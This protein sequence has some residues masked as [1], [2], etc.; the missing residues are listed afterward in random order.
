V[1][2]SILHV[3]MDAFYASVELLRRPELRG[4][5]VVVGGAGARGVV[6][7]ASYEAR[8]YGVHS[9]MPALRARRL[10]P[11]AVFLAGDHPHYAQVSARLM[12]IFR[13]VTPLVEPLSLDEAF[14]DISGTRRL[15][16][17]PE[18]V[19]AWLR[20]RV[21]DEEQLSCSVGV[22]SNKFLAK[23]ATNRAKPRASRSGPIE[24]SGVFVVE[25]GSELDFLHPLP[26][27]DLWGVGP[28]T[29]AKLERLGIATVGDL[30]AAPLAALTASLGRGAATHLHELAHGR[31][32]RPVVPDQ[33]P[34]SV[35]HEETFAADL[36]H[37]DELRPELV[38]MSDA[39]AARLRRHGFRGR[40][41]QLKLRYGDFSTLT[42]STTLPTATD[43]GTEVLATAWAMLER[44]D[45]HRGV[46]LVGVGV[47]NLSRE[48]APEQLSLDDPVD[49]G[50]DAANQVV[51]EIRDRFGSSLIRPAR[52]A[53]RAERSGSAQ[54]GP[55]GG[56]PDGDVSENRPGDRS[57][58]G[59]SR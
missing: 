26:V 4:R 31:D 28:A 19:A 5:P 58:R 51:D 21:R 7:A 32:D 56:D 49:D 18:Q 38:R 10:C 9:A 11:D 14:L 48:A 1:A 36:H 40:T 37:L 57:G 24:G 34:K 46:R 47:S 42:R 25:P 43:R 20:A 33:D 2:R 3:D 44:L 22:A 55:D 17:P 59:P 16:G 41:V 27:G 13:S 50:W 53:G 45:V 52:L 30:A 15:L 12:E 54:W 39:V 8:S 35:S 29:L 23:L 6:A